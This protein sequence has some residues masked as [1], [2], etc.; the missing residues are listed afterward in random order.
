MDTH[1]RDAALHDA[2]L[3]QAVQRFFAN[4]FRFR[5]RASLSEFWWVFLAV[6]L[7]STALGY[8]D[9]Q[10]GTYLAAVFSL[11]MIVPFLA[12]FSRRLPDAGFS[13]IMLLLLIVSVLGGL[14]LLGMALFTSAGEESTWNN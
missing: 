9:R 10:L 7:V 14:I 12:L 3:G 1:G 13:P 11:V 5:G 2:T 6:A 4:A 8:S